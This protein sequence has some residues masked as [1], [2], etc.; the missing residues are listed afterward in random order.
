MLGTSP[1]LVQIHGEVLATRRAPLTHS[2]C[3]FMCAFLWLVTEQYT[4][5]REGQLLFDQTIIV[6]K[7][8]YMLEHALLLDN[9]PLKMYQ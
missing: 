3:F 5:A 4:T 2:Y 1:C 7:Q 6:E 8:S 9:H